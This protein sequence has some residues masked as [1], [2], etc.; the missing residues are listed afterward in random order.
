[1]IAVPFDYFVENAK[2]IPSATVNKVKTNPAIVNHTKEK[3]HSLINDRKPYLT[4]SSIPTLMD[5]AAPPTV[6]DPTKSYVWSPAFGL[7]EN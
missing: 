2:I 3:D 4:E 1:M 5:N 7:K 6:T